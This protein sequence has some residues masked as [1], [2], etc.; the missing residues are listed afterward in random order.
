[1]GGQ[2]TESLID[3]RGIANRDFL[4]LL[5]SACRHLDSRFQDRKGDL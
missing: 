3:L 1:M 5:T 2:L 4:T